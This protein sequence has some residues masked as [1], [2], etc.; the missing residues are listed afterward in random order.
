M[1]MRGDKR[2]DLGKYVIADLKIRGRNFEILVDPD[3]AWD[4]KKQMRV[5]QKEK[6]KQLN[7]TYKL[8]VED[9]IKVSKVPMEELI[10]GFLVFE[11]L[12]R[13]EKV[14][15]ETLEDYFGTSDI[16][17]VTARF[18]LDGNLQLTKEQREKF[19][20][21]KRK[22]LIDILVKNCVNPQTGKPH[23]PA[24]IERA[25]EEGK[26]NIDPFNPVEDQVSDVVKALKPV[27]PIKMERVVLALRIPAEFTGKGYN[28]I[29]NFSSISE[30]KWGN[31]GS[32]TCSIDLPAGIQAEFLEKLNKLTRGRAQVKVIETI[33]E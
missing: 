29:N 23:P 3:L 12:K 10:E 31:D 26:V 32:L 28:M 22:K 27:I 19:I 17:E 16:K 5:F 1:M 21:E 6:E 18:M 30:E 24:R 15:D 4:L 25:L 11:N 13:G 14:S 8:T 33:S 20:A 2:I 9:V 7:E